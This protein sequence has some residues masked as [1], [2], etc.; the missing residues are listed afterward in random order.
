M[1]TGLPVSRLIN[2]TINMSPRAAEGADLNTGLLLGASDVIDATERMRTYATLDD[3]ASEFGSTAPEYLAA[4]LYFE[5]APQPSRLRVG[6]WVKS[7]TAGRLRGG[8]LSTAQQSIDQWTVVT[9]G[10]FKIPIDGVSK[11][12]SALDFSAQTNLNGVASIINAAIDGASCVWAGDRFVI[13]SD[14]TGESSSVGYAIKPTSGTNIA[15]K[16]GLTSD[17]ASAP[18]DGALAESPVDAVVQMLDRFANQF[19]GLAFA[20]DSVT[21]DQHC[22]VAQLIEGD[23]AHMY[24]VTTQN[25]QAMDATVSTDIASRLKA[26][27]LKYSFLQYSSENPF[28]GVSLLARMLGVNFDANS[29]TITLMYKQEPGIAAESISTSQANALQA[30]RCNVFVNYSNDT[31]I[32]QDGVTPSGVYIDS[33]YNSIWLKNRIQTDVYNLL[34]Q[35]TT[36]VPQ[37]DDGNALIAAVIEQACD[38]A[39]NNDYLAP[40]I[41]NSDGFGVLKRGAMLTKGYYVYTPSIATQAQSA[42]EARQSVPFQ[43]AAKEAGAIHSVDVLI[44]VNR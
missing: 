12:V 23:Q 34:Y 44:N 42:R 3:V 29:S 35:S 26:L 40:G 1:A 14:S 38:A 2:V 17:L 37:T 36:K 10:G 31:A 39:V 8:V 32:V 25:P 18:A 4:A 33:V 28:A 16:L 7:D 24:A 6:R 43:I 9:N 11:A 20:D 27:T 22:A 21:D 5:Q 41:W 19:L 30:K 15:A 13:T